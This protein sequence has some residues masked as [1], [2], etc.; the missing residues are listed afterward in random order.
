MISNCF[1]LIVRLVANC[2]TRKAPSEGH[3]S[4]VTALNRL[5]WSE[6][7]LNDVIEEW[8]HTCN[9][10][11]EN[12]VKPQCLSIINTS[13][14]NNYKQTC[15]IVDTGSTGHYITDSTPQTIVQSDPADLP[16]V[17]LPDNTCITASHAVILPL[18][19][20]LTHEASLAY[21]F[22]NIAKPLIS[23]GKLWD[24]DCTAIYTREKCYIVKNEHLNIPS[25][26]KNSFLTGDRDAC[27]TLWTFNLQ[28]PKTRNG[29]ANTVY[30][31][32]I[33]ELIHFQHKALFSHTKSTLLH[34]IKKYSF[35]HDM[36]STLRT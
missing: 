25:L 19:L 12:V 7:G 8:H 33:K 24:D 1:D 2:T 29:S 22:P 32:K 9:Y 31:M 5:G 6:I 36:V 26:T 21:T 15:A 10:T 17:T 11:N 35:Q 30:E 27:I 4:E 3:K 34:A 16:T 13:S 23:I 28:E 20:Q 14:S 18:S